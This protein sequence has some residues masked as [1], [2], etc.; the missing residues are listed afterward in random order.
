MDGCLLR[1]HVAGTNHL[2]K[3]FLEAGRGCS[4]KE[5][6]VQPAQP[7]GERS[8]EANRSCPHHRSPPRPPKAQATLD[9]EG[10]DNAFLD[11]AQGLHEHSNAGETRRN[12]HEV[13][14]LIDIVFSEE[15]MQQVD[16]PLVVSVVGGHVV[17]ANLVIEARSGPSDR[18][19]IKVT[20][21]DFGDLWAYLDNSAT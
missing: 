10:L 21:L 6:H 17:M 15:A 5:R 16:A 12:P 11:D 7:E 14:R 2:G 4:C 9:F 13:L 8:Q 19:R 3:I 18:R 20:R 1:A